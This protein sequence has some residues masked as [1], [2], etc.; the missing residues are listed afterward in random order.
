MAKGKKTAAADGVP[1]APPDD[2]T[3]MIS[4]IRDKFRQIVVNTYFPSKKVVEFLAFLDAL[5]PKA[6]AANAA[7][8]PEPVAKPEPIEPEST[9]AAGA[10][11][12]PG[13][14]G[15]DSVG[16]AGQSASRGRDSG[17]VG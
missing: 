5:K 11:S 17:D 2:L 4:T 9:D 12:G 14:V 10:S 6:K 15:R 8:K 7:P 16:D 13:Y 3:R 1:A